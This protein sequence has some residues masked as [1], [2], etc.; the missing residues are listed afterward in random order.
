MPDAVLFDLDGTLADTAPDL[1]AALNRLQAEQ[2]LSPTALDT[3]RPH[4]SHGVRGMLR[5]GFALSPD[6]PAYGPLAARFLELYSQ[7]LCVETRL[8]P[9]IPQLLDHLDSHDIPW[10]V[11]TN[12]A[13]RLARPIVD[14]LNLT[15]R[16]ACI[17]GGDT[18]PHPK[19]HPAPLLHACHTLNAD[20]SRSFY[21]GD[22]IRDILAGSAA[23]MGTIAVRYGYLG[24]G[25]AIE[26]WQ[27]DAI[28]NNPLEVLPFLNQR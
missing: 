28:V 17:V 25:Q 3:L 22:D 6:S 11:V 19:P 12:K 15:H 21:L 2:G 8:F 9:G 20:P 18:T 27:A 7:A 26:S 13:E 16:C 14:A 5:I 4:V 1:G 24:V 23:G 10:G